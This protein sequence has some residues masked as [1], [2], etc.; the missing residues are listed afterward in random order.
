[1]SNIRAQQWYNGE[2]PRNLSGFIND[3]SNRFIGW[4]TMRQLRIKSD[5]CSVQTIR[6]T[7]VYD[8]NL[9][10]EEKRSFAPGWINETIEEYSSSISKA[11]E[12]KSSDELDTYVYVGDH[13]SY[14]GNGYVYEFRGR[15]SDLQSNLSQLHQLGW[16]DNQTRA[17]IIQLSL[18][19]PN[20]ELFTSVTLLT[21]FLS[22][23]GIYPEARF[24]PFN[25]YSNSEFLL[26][27]RI[28]YF[29]SI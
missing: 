20:V 14:S 10:N 6:S 28:K 23:G 24:E 1:V 25:F 22:T 16:I 5:L 7:C 2:A 29:V 8:Y 4:A 11:F 9:F 12:Y 19:N 13:G 27:L 18:Y 26:L 15:L 17:V 21:E 3:K